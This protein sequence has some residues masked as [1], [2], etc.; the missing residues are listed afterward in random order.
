MPKCERCKTNDARVRIDQIVMGKREHHY[1]C[2]SCAQ[3]VM[4]GQMGNAGGT[5]IGNI[6][7]NMGGQPTGAAV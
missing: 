5:P 4:G 1:L 2:E 3:E 7:A 6:F